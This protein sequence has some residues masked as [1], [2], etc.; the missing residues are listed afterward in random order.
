M[1]KKWKAWKLMLPN[2]R[3]YHFER[4]QLGYVYLT[5]GCEVVITMT[6]T[7]ARRLCLKLS[8]DYKD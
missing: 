2:I 8:G 4:D 7:E 6:P 1:A 3:P 5:D